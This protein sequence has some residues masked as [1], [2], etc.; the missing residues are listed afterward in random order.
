MMREKRC[1]TVKC[2]FFVHKQKNRVYK[3][4]RKAKKKDK[5]IDRLDVILQ[6]LSELGGRKKD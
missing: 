2:D 3:V 1:P 6:K 5:L 4:V